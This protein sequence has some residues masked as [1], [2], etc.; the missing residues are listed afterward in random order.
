MRNL[1]LLKIIRMLSTDP[2]W[3]KTLK[4]F[5]IVGLLGFFLTCALVIWGTV[6]AYN[7]LGKSNLTVVNNLEQ[8]ATIDST[9]PTNESTQTCLG[10]AKTLLNAQVWVNKPLGETF[11]NLKNA[12]L[13]TAPKSPAPAPTPA[14]ETW[15]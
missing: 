1:F 5:A 15:S 2:N 6:S 14:D 8:H 13:H 3:R 7:Y 10:H 4:K 9:A 12:C 11:R